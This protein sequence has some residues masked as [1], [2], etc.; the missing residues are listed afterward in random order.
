[1]TSAIDSPLIDPAALCALLDSPEP[2][3]IAD[4]RFALADPGLGERQYA[5]GHLP[6]A[7]YV[8]LER[9]LSAPRGAVGGRH[10][11]PPL[12]DF[13]ALLRRHGLDA[14]RRVVAYDDSRGAY[15][16][17][18]WWMLRQAGHDA[19]QV[20]DGGIGAWR[21][22][23]LALETAPPPVPP[24]GDFVARPRTHMQIGH[25]ELRAALG[26]GA[27]CVVDAREPRRYAGLEEP[28]DPVAGHVPGAV[29]RPWMDAT[30][31]DGRFLPP[32]AQR[33]RFEA[34]GEPGRIVVYC[35]SGV[36]ACVDL[37]A[38]ELAGLGGARLYPG[39]WSDWCDRSGPVE[40][41]S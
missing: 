33:A 29:N 34:L 15:A 41:G 31:A 19:V 35:G 13:A 8:H 36:T 39:S 30:G 4:C 21:A 16:A 5:E 14:G 38:L 10:P 27:L 28:I 18:L 23:G 6:G 20:L 2:P 24:A 26:S 7:R 25:E 32:A 37:L 1:M 40:R 9:D 22:A 3:L 17:R 12:A 11:L